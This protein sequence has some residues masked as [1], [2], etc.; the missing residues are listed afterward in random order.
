MTAVTV[1]YQIPEAQKERN[2]SFQHVED[3]CNEAV[4]ELTDMYNNGTVDGFAF[5]GW[6]DKWKTSCTY[7][8]L[9]KA[10]SQFAQA[11]GVT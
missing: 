3:K 8:H 11:N 5:V 10:I 7:K 2:P 1:H 4:Q 9:G 6:F